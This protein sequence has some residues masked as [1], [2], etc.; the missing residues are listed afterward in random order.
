MR[1]IHL[2]GS[3]DGARLTPEEASGTSLLAPFFDVLDMDA[4]FHVR[5]KAS[6]GELMLMHPESRCMDIILE[7][8]GTDV[9]SHTQTDFSEK[10]CQNFG[11]SLLERLSMPCRL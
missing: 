8:G 9:R 2:H 5:R 11:R 10:S 7:I 6:G 3:D 1:V 4:G